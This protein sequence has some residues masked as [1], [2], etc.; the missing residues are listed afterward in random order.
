MFTIFKKKV[1]IWNV[2]LFTICS[3]GALYANETSI[4]QRKIGIIVEKMMDKEVSVCKFCKTVINAGRI[5]SDG[6]HIVENHIKNHLFT[7]GIVSQECD[8]TIDK[9]I[10]V[11]LYRFEEKI[12]GDFSVEKPASVG[13]HMHLLDKTTPV[14]SYTFDEE[15]KPLLANLLGIGKFL[16]RKGRW[17]DATTLS[18]EGVKKGLEKLIG[19]LY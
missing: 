19:E 13:F 16:K 17:I 18:E 11:L 4:Q 9:C 5:H 15:Q 14:R 2:L 12:G 8:Y 10:Y 3:I 1:L 6:P 7:K